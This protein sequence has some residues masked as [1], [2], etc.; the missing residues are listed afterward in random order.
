VL[1][2]GVGLEKQEAGSERVAVNHGAI[3][4]RPGGGIFVPRDQAD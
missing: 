1:D 2:E 4:A 3:V